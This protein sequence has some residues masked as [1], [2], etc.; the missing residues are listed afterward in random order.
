MA[1]PSQQHENDQVRE[2]NARERLLQ[3][4]ALAR[5]YRDWSAKELAHAL[6]RQPGRLVPESGMPKI[7][8]IAGLASALDWPIDA[9]VDHIMAAAGQ[10][11]PERT[12]EP[13]G[14]SVGDFQSLYEMAMRARATRQL[15]RAHLLATRALAAADQPDRRAA[16]YAVL[17]LIEDA[18][19]CYLEAQRIINT[20]LRLGG[21][22]SGWRLFLE[23]ILANIY[24]VRGDASLALGLSS[25]I[26]ER[27]SAEQVPGPLDAV[28]RAN[29]HWARGQVLRAAIPHRH[30]DAWRETARRARDDFQLAEQQCAIAEAAA[31]DAPIYV[32]GFIDSIRAIA[33]ELEPI[34]G[35]LTA[36]SA[37]DRMLSIARGASA[38]EGGLSESKAWA[39]LAIANTARRFVRDEYQRRGLLEVA[40]LTLRAHAIETNNWFFAHCHLEIEAERRR[41]LANIGGALRSLDPVEARLVTGVLGQIDAARERAGDFLGL[42]GSVPGAE[43]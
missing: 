4:Q 29:A 5:S 18:R 16:A 14:A 31:S 6:G 36:E 1:D 37:I 43:K 10:G 3:L 17:A 19:G 11:A 2:A 33:L 38:G 25:S 34:A 35:N 41:T 30:H 40:S 20:A 42:Y 23:A 21:V 13:S 32:G 27:S 28:V 39:A 8:L 9:V 22:Q 12:E 15:D 24:F 26:I 7:D